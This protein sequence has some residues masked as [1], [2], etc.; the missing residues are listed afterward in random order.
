[1]LLNDIMNRQDAQIAGMAFRCRADAALGFEYVDEGSKR[2][3]GYNQAELVE[4]GLITLPDLIQPAGRDDVRRMI[5]DGITRRGTFTVPFGIF[6][7]DRSPAEGLLIGK[8]VFNGPLDLT[9]IE[10]YILRMQPADEERHGSGWLL[11]EDL[12]Q[13]MLDHTGDIIAYIGP[14]GM[15]RY[16]TPSVMRILGYRS[17]QITGKAFTTL[18]M[19]EEQERFDDVRQR[20]DTIGGGGSSARFIGMTAEGAPIQILIR[21]FASGGADR[22]AILTASPASEEKPIMAPVS[23]LYRA[24]CEASPVPLIITRRDDRRIVTV[25][26]AFL[27]LTGRS[28][29]EEV[30]GLSLTATGLQYS[31]EEFSRI[32]AVLDLN[33]IFEGTESSIRTPIG[34][35]PIL[36]SARSFTA[37]GE[38]A[39]TWS[40]VPIPTKTTELNLP[41]SE[42][43]MENIRTF[44]Q[45]FKTDLQLLDSILKMKG[46]HAK[47]D[48]K[49]TN[50]QDRSFL[51]AISS[52]YQKA[53][54]Q[55]GT[56]NVSICAYLNTIKTHIIEEYSDRIQ[57]VTVSSHCEGD[58]SI[59]NTVGIPIGIITTELLVNAVTHAFSPGETGRIEL[60][61]TREEDWF[62]LQVRDSGKGLPDEVTQGQPSSAGLAMVE[63]LAMQIS[64]TA[65]FSNDGGA[66][67]RIIF[68]D[69]YSK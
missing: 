40:L 65:S 64:G 37:A 66:R 38:E 44:S 20:I 6:T 55:S 36:L 2:V 67:V 15:V 7:K 1:M 50:R 28:D 9:A 51:H 30:T 57:S 31:P 41:L 26:E 68:P 5:Q 69:P 59:G 63:N 10:G 16:I 58:W 47:S 4:T 29:P 27:H 39:V 13:R 52:F 3:S 35:T 22:S 33:R 8:G 62:I 19:P 42:T 24:A 12:W 60:S 56:D 45:G 21:L 48:A 17:D 49:D 54:G 53:A 43:G 25:N 61:V 18:L 34:T 11:P 32:E 23:D 14:E 46:L